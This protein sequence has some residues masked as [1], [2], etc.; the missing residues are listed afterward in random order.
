M[1][2]LKETKSEIRKRM[3]G[4]RN[5]LSIDEIAEYSTRITGI[6]MKQE[7]FISSGLIMFYVNTGSEVVTREL[8]KK[9][10]YLRKRAA[11]PMV[12]HGAGG[13]KTMAACEITNIE[14]ET[15]MGSYGILEPK[16]SMVKKVLPGDIDMIIVPGVAFDAKGYR[17]GYG[18]GYYDRFLKNVRKDCMKAGIAYEFQVVDELP[19]ED[20]DI[21]LDMIITQERIITSPHYI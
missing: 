9:A 2:I 1:R 17:I 5:N 19:K 15:E 14:E 13:K 4:I 11:I 7:I 8:I 20:H 18:G 16:K 3:L 10:V 12:E 6:L 21:P